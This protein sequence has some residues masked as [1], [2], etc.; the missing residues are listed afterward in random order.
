MDDRINFFVGWESL[1]LINA[2]LAQGEGCSGLL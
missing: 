1:A 2:G